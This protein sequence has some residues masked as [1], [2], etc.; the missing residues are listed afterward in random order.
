LRSVDALYDN[1]DAPSARVENSITTASTTAKTF[2]IVKNLLRFEFKIYGMIISS[3][4]T[5]CKAFF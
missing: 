5:K 4:N 2:F 1:A 3:K